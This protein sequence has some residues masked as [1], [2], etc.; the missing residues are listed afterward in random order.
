MSSPDLRLFSP[1][2]HIF[3]FCQALPAEFLIAGFRL[4]WHIVSPS[5][6]WHAADIG[7]IHGTHPTLH[8]IA[9]VNLL[10]QGLTSRAFLPDWL[11]LERGVASRLWTPLRNLLIICDSVFAFGVWTF[12]QSDRDL[13]LV[14]ELCAF[15]F[16]LLA[17]LL[18]GL[19]LDA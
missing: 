5:P 17:N 13:L 3:P 10:N 8:L 7:S 12:P 2:Q 19:I 4:S 14:H 11:T 6:M 1:L 15:T 18:F 9:P 16:L